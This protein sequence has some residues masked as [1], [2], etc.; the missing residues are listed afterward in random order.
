MSVYVPEFVS[1]SVLI[2]LDVCVCADAPVSVSVCGSLVVDVSGDVADDTSCRHADHHQ[3]HACRGVGGHMG[4]W[5]GEGEGWMQGC[6][7]WMGGCRRGG[8][9]KGGGGK[10]GVLL[11]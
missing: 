4:G 1:A 9:C 11:C 2:C 6:C 10:A 3:G 8:E 5:V 7:G